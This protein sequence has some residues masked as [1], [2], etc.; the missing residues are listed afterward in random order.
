[1][2][3]SRFFH[4]AGSVALSEIAALTGAAPVV[5]GGGEINPARLFTGVAPLETAGTGDVAFIDNV[6]YLDAFAAS[7]A[8]ACFVRENHADR[9]PP[10]M[11]LLIT[12]EPYIAHAQ[13]AARFYPDAALV[14]GISSLASVAGSAEIG[15]GT[16]ID[17]FAVIGESVTIGKRCHIGAGAVL[18]SGV[19]IGD[20]CRIGAQ[21]SISHAIIGHRFIM[22]PGARIGQDGF[23]F[24]PGPKGALKVPQLGRALIGDDVEIGAGT[25]IDR[26]SGRD[27]IIGDGCKIDNLVQI[28]HNVRIGRHVMI[29]GL[30]GVAGSTRIDDGV[31]IGGQ[32]GIAGHVTIGAGAKV[33]ARA[34]V[35][36]DIPP[37]ATFG[38]SPAQPMRDWHRQ[39][40]AL[41]ALA[42]KKES[43]D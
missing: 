37:G 35:M 3:D 29:A 30:V 38:G 27:T 41:A 4:N 10:G 15:S 19:Q 23:G 16:R 14:S 8:G 20:D 31:M 17:P 11:I 2:V 25:C 43:S 28:G 6:K 7:Q 34:G 1:M 24:A 9:A 26:G 22:H 21:C 40:I 42:N 13:T 18:E 32:A 12:D 33:A 39:T 36:T 5:S